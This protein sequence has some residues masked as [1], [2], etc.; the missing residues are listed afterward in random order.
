MIGN[1]EILEWEMSNLILSKFGFYFFVTN[2]RH[3]VFDQI[4]LNLAN[5]LESSG[6]KD[7]DT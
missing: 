5:I 1:L 3:T 4:K 6:L 2:L 7:T